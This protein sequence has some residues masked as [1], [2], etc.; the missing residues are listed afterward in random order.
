MCTFLGDKIYH[1]KQ[2]PSRDTRCTFG[3]KVYLLGNG[4]YLGQHIPSEPRFTFLETRFTF[5]ETRCTFSN[6]VCLIVNK[7]YL[8]EDNMYCTL[9]GPATNI[10]VRNSSSSKRGSSNSASV[11][12]D[13]LPKA[14]A[15]DDKFNLDG[16]LETPFEARAEVNEANPN[17]L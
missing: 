15:A 6:K 14:W 13:N 12:T 9:G 3:N 8:I 10:S 17:N 1:R 5:L 7:V 4:V 11:Y 2:V 16:I